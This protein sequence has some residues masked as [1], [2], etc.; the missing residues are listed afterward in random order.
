MRILLVDDDAA[1][2]A[3]LAEYLTLLGHAATPCA[4]GS[5][6]L[7][8]CRT[9]AF[10]MVFSDINMPGIS[11]IELVREVKVL[12][13]PGNPDVVLYTGH[14]DVALAIGALRAGAYD[15][16]TK[17]INLEELGAVLARVAEHQSLLS[18]NDRLTRRFDEEVAA[19]TRDTRQELDRLRRLL[20]EQAGMDNVGV[21]SEAMWKVVEQAKRFHEDRELPV[22]IQGETGV[23]K[24]LVAKIVHYGPSQ[25]PLPFVDI[26]CTALSPGLFESELFGYEAGAYTGGAARGGRGKLDLAQGGTLFLDEIAEIP[27]ELQAKLLRVIEDKSFYRVGGLKKLA[28]DIRI[29]AATNLDFEDRISR[30][31]FRKDLYFRLRVGGI[32]IPPLRERPDDIVPLARMFLTAFA[33]KRGKGFIGI[34]RQAASMLLAYPWPGNVRELR[35][36]MEWASVMH[37]AAELAPVHLAGF[38][39]NPVARLQAAPPAQAPRPRGARPS[40]ADIEA[41]IAASGGNKTRAAQSLGI[42]IRML[43]YRLKQGD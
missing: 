20:A 32:V 33:K 5:S 34:N 22:L 1:T 10:D 27:V 18:E 15:Y 2:R 3:S 25:A 29:I 35:N 39:A 16:L 36:A 6:A 12:P 42:S 21:F 7:T 31:L 30:G 38:F 41:A 13:G 26:N 43:H 14:S 23:G 37:D 8:L 28:T 11:G 17:P 19:A 9:H 40:R 4:D 24:E